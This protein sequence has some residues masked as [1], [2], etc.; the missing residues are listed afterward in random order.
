[1]SKL[2]TSILKSLR[3]N[4]TQHWQEWE[5]LGCVHFKSLSFLS[6]SFSPLPAC[7]Y[8]NP[9]FCSSRSPSLFLI[10]FALTF[11]FSVLIT[12]HI[13]LL[14][15]S[16]FS[17]FFHGTYLCLWLTL[18]VAISVHFYSIWDCNWQ[19]LQIHQ[20]ISPG[21]TMENPLCCPTSHSR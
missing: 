20:S 3:G 8:K 7:Y 1:M 14:K 6:P 10:F 19:N 5:F 18:W 4:Y 2:K 13:S 17:F 21:L 12:L 15:I 16:N 9:W 11:P